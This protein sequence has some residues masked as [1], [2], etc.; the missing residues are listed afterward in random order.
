M[1]GKSSGGSVAFV[2]EGFVLKRTET[3]TEPGFFYHQ[4]TETG[5]EMKFLEP[6]S[7][8]AQRLKR[9]ALNIFAK[10]LLMSHLIQ[11]Y[12]E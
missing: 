4:K 5:T 6:H 7:S 8:I 1:S 10:S 12:E 2:I 11:N 3:G 9:C